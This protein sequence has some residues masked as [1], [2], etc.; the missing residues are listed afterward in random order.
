MPSLPYCWPLKPFGREHPVRAYFNDPR[1]S[2]RSRAFHFGI[3]ISTKDGSPVYAVEEGV[4]HIEGGRSLSVVAP[5]GRTFG[6][7][8]IVPAVHHH[9][10]V[11]RHQLVG[12]VDA[13]WGHVH[14]AERYRQ[15]YRNPLRPGALTPWSDPSSPRIDAIVFQRGRRVLSPLAVR[16][17][18][19]VIVEA[20]DVPPL[21]VP[22][23]W[24]NMPVTPALLRWRVLRSTKVVRGWHAPVDF[25]KSLIARELFPA[26]FAPGTRQNH[27]NEPG[28]YRFYL[29]HTWSTRLLPNG[30]YRL[31]VEAGDESG[32]TA[33]ASL[34]FTVA[35][36]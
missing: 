4:V 6:Y 35:N 17:A 12:H 23:P 36:P 33:R 20:H 14:F 29:A 8:H 11:R 28:L 25:R 22:P 32:N 15:R 18:V 13:P 3:D 31:Q 9:A 7:W 10:R 16:G 27:P 26:I 2:G 24:S 19:D 34:P 21:H 30:L 5:G 1:I